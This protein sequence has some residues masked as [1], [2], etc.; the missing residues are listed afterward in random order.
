M[1][2]WSTGTGLQDTQRHC[3]LAGPS[4]R[5]NEIREKGRE[6]EKE[7]RESQEKASQ[8]S[9]EAKEAREAEEPKT[10]KTKISFTQLW[11]LQA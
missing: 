6:E 11:T 3:N 7:P 1:R 4:I 10:K 2:H 5:V 8:E 9:Q